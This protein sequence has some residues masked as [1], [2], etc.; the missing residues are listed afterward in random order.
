MQIKILMTCLLGLATA[1]AFAQKGE[2]KDAQSNYDSY[3]TLKS[4]KV[5]AMQ[6]QAKKAIADAKTS[7]DKAAANDKTA[8]LPQTFP[9]KAAIYSSMAADDTVAK[10]SA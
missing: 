1:A 5:A 8:A 6:V 4:Q 10:T 7:I 9:L 2:L 3:S